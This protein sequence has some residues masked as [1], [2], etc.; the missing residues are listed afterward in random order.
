VI[1]LAIASACP[2]GDDGSAAATEGSS[3]ASSTPATTST[4]SPDDGSTAASGSGGDTT[5]GDETA[6]AATTDGGDTTGGA[7]I[8]PWEEGSI[9]VLPA[10]EVDLVEHVLSLEHP[11]EG[12][13]VVLEAERQASFEALLTALDTALALTLS[14][15]EAADWCGVLELAEAA[16]YEIHRLRDTATG[17]WL[18]YGADTTAGGQAYFFVNP[19]AKRDLVIEVPHHPFDS[20]TAQEG[21]RILVSLSARALL[22]AKEHRCS[23][24]DDAQCPA[25][26]TACGGSYRESDVA[27]DP[28]NTFH[29]LHAWYVEKSESRFVQLH[30]F[31]APDGDLAEIGDGTNNDV[32]PRSIANV[33]AEHLGEL[34]GDPS[35]VFS[36]QAEVGAPPAAMCGGSNVQAHATHAPRADACPSTGDGTNRFLH[37]EQSATLRDEDE[38]DEASWTDVRDALALTWPDCTLGRGPRDCDLGPAQGS[39]RACA[40]GQACR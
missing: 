12:D 27:H 38:T 14:D 31:D 18:V 37:V 6:S 11:N 33:F 28:R 29:V 19:E 23:D 20:N 34:V 35:A 26:T 24:P 32:D 1:L 25:N 36:C 3:T 2:G 16:G 4:A 40:C 9:R 17:R 22:L 39:P 8:L 5:V 15:P 13:Y 21:A 30:G 10:I 7:P